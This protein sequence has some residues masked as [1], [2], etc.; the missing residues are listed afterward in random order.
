MRQPRLQVM[1]AYFRDT[2]LQGSFPT[3][4][5]TAYQ[6]RH[7]TNNHV[8]GWNSKLNKSI[9]RHHPNLHTLI[10][11]LKTMQAETELTIRRARLGGAPKPGRRKYRLLDSRIQRLTD[12]FAAGNLTPIQ[13]LEDSSEVVQQLNGGR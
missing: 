8:E 12:Q 2:W 11:H 10:H 6:Q 5:W 7:R 4:M 9:G 13:L 1:V 3:T